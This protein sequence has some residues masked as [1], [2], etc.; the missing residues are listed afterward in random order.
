MGFNMDAKGSKKKANKMG[1]ST[2]KKTTTK[3]N[4]L[5]RG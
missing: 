1:K 5:Y 4:I 2:H 3:K